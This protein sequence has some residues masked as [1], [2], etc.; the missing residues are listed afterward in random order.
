MTAF[1]DSSAVVKLYADEEGLA[2]V[3]GLT[4]MVVSQIARV[5]VPAALWA[6]HRRG[7]LAAGD[8]RTLTAEFEADY[9]GTE[10]EDTRFAAV[11]LRA[12][13]LDAAARLSAAHGLRAYDAVQLASALTAHAADP[14]CTAFAAFD[15]SLRTA[16]AA[17]GF[18]LI[19]PD[20]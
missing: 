6:K 4:A 19:P 9:F 8:A 12:P 11:A 20:P 1:A 14:S 10:D 13:I 15:G 18:T 17:E 2:E 7:E 5:E 3:R 16:A